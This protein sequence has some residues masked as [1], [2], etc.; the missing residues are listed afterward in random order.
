[1]YRSIILT[2]FALLLVGCVTEGEE[3]QDLSEYTKAPRFLKYEIEERIAALEFQTEEA[4]YQN[5]VRLVYIGEP[6]IPFIVG[7]LGHK[8]ARVRAS[9]AYVLGVVRDR[10]TIGAL[11]VHL[12]DQA[13][14]VR[15]EVA[16]SLGIMGVRDSYPVLI[17]GLKD[18][19]IRNR[20]KAHEALT[21]LTKNDFGYKHDDTPQTRAKAVR[22]WEEWYR[23][24]TESAG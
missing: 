23:R 24:M 16:T 17:E 10:R 1:M 9:C 18:A 12:G 8:A 5:I 6:A 13:S 19:E 4:L 3:Q 22:L 21:M 2:A 14:V 7:G 11:Q 20:Y 15:Y